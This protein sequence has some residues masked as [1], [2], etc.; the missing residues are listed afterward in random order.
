MTN[1]HG[2]IHLHR[3]H[4]HLTVHSNNNLTAYCSALL[5]TFL[6]LGAA[7][8]EI[9]GLPIE[10]CL[11]FPITPRTFVSLFRKEGHLDHLK[12]KNKWII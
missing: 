5:P 3:T 11:D 6:T 10:I 9:N 12:S 4:L 2:Y 1:N 8:Y 7:L